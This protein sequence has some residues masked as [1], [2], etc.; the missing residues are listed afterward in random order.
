MFSLYYFIQLK[1]RYHCNFCIVGRYFVRSRASAIRKRFSWKRAP[2]ADAAV[3]GEVLGLI[4]KGQSIGILFEGHCS[5]REAT[6]PQL[7]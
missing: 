7:L 1:T 2:Q 5:Y 3:A 6:R 4:N